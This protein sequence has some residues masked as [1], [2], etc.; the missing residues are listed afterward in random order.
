MTQTGCPGDRHVGAGASGAGRPIF[1][2]SDGQDRRPAA[3]SRGPSPGSRIGSALPT[4]PRL[5]NVNREDLSAG[6]FEPMSRS[7]FLPVRLH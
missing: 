3:G 5:G 6:G 7:R 4:A 2:L 1:R